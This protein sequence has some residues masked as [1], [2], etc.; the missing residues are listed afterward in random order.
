MV[1]SEPWHRKPSRSETNTQIS[2][3]IIYLWFEP[4]KHCNKTQGFVEKRQC[5]QLKKVLGLESER[6]WLRSKCD[7]ECYPSSLFISLFF[8]NGILMSTSA[9]FLRIKWDNIH[10]SLDWFLAR[11]RDKW[12]VAFLI[13]DSLWEKCDSLKVLQILKLVFCPPCL[14]GTLR[15][16]Y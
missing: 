13:L 12:V 10:K 16:G 9:G 15:L 7:L 3:A 14:K 5:S 4:L 6:P 1:T 2:G 8:C 11:S